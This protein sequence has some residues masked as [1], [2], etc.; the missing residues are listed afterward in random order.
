MDDGK[1]FGYVN[2]YPVRNSTLYVAFV[3]YMFESVYLSIFLYI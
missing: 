3:L 2:K 1:M